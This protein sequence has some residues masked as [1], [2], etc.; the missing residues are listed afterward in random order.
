MEEGHLTSTSTY[1]LTLYPPVPFRDPQHSIGDVVSLSATKASQAVSNSLDK[2]GQTQL[3]ALNQILGQNF[4]YQLRY[5]KG[6]KGQQIQPNSLTFFELIILA[7]TVHEIAPQYSTLE[8]NCHWFCHTLFD[9]CKVIY[10]RRLED[11][12]NPHWDHSKILG[13]WNG[14]KASETKREELSV[15]VHNFKKAYCKV[16]GEVQNFF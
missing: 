10:G 1:T 5:G 6:Q 9:A 13:R 3:K 2:D 16:I 7:Q 12:D 15:V 14:L 11:D 4:L 8:K